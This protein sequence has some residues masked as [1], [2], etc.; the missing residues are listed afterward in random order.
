M[1]SLKHRVSRLEDEG[2]QVVIISSLGPP[3]EN[4]EPLTKGDSNDFVIRA[5]LG[6]P[7]PLADPG[8]T[9]ANW[10]GGKITANLGEPPEGML[11]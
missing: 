10:S 7:P 5:F 11:H 2:G 4:L 1:R 6:T 8:Q 9:T 3:P